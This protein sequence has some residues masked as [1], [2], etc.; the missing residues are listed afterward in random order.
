MKTHLRE[1]MLI[2]EKRSSV[3]H[4]IDYKKISVIYLFLHLFY[5]FSHLPPLILWLVALAGNP[6]APSGAEMMIA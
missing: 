4:P 3:A 1:I 2:H 5:I 6:T